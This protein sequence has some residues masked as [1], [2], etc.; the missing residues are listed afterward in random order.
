MVEQ[1]PQGPHSSL[2]RSIR[3]LIEHFKS[4][5]G[6][7]KVNLKIEDDGHFLIDVKDNES[8]VTIRHD[9]SFEH[10]NT[11]D[12]FFTDV[13]KDKSY[14][15]FMTEC[16]IEYFPQLL[17]EVFVLTRSFIKRD[18]IV[19]KTR[20]LKI[21]KREDIRFDVPGLVYRYAARSK[22]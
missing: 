8:Q 21:F 13:T 6:A 11:I 14:V 18:Y 12:I 4:F 22:K 19:E 7:T 16:D 3:G 9:A 17:K 2:L 1:E 5:P 10:P 15:I 20:F